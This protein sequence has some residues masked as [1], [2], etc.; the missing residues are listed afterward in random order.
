MSRFDELKVYSASSHRGALRVGLSLDGGVDCSDYFR[1]FY[2]GATISKGREANQLLMEAVEAALGNRPL[3]EELPLHLTA[4]PFQKKVWRAITQIPFGETRSYG[5][6]ARSIGQPGAARAVG[7]A[8]HRN[9]L[10]LIF[11]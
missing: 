3:P 9:P 11:P 5:E 1:G 4:T 8:M 2:P 10:P 6:V 7:Q